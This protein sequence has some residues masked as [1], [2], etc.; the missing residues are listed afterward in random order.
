MMDP[1]SPIFKWIVPRTSRLNGGLQWSCEME[2][3]HIR[4]EKMYFCF[5]GKKKNVQSEMLALNDYL[6]V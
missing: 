2:V 3:S 5:F 4:W 1:F 6:L